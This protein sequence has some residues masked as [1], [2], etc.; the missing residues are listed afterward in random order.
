MPERRG[1]AREG[2]GGGERENR[3][4]KRERK[5]ERGSAAPP[6]FLTT[7]TLDIILYPPCDPLPLPPPPPPPAPLPPNPPTTRRETCPAGFSPYVRAEERYTGHVYVGRTPP[8]GT[9]Q[10]PRFARRSP[11]RLLPRPGKR[12]PK[13]ILADS[14]Q[15]PA[16]SFAPNVTE[17]LS[18]II[19]RPI[20]RVY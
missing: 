14:P 6:P 4:K 16:P 13:G 20:P 7:P 5:T 12:F 11:S 10:C 9:I 15:F 2:G 17:L 3:A 8:R 19:S 1:A 18:R